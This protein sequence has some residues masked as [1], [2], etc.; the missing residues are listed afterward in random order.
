MADFA[1]SQRILA[2]PGRPEIIF[3]DAAGTLFRV[4]EGVGVVYSRLAAEHGVALAPDQLQTAFARAF[5]TMPPMIAPPH[6]SEAELHTCERQWWRALVRRVFAQQEFQRGFDAFFDEVFEYFR[7]AE[8][9]RIFNDVRPALDMLRAQGRRMAIISN[10]DSRLDDLLAS[11]ELAHYFEAVHLSTRIGAAKP[12]PRIFTHA[13]QFHQVAPQ[14]ALHIG[15][16]LRED[17][18]GATAAGIAAVL[19]NRAIDD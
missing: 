13:L 2:A 11:L 16:S 3:F 9:W 4:R 14:H 6:E 7:A 8:A 18:E 17:I 19:L 10:F 5:T 12:D 15:D 1:Q